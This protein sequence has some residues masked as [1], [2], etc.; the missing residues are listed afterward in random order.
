MLFCG[1]CG[2]MWQADAPT[3]SKQPRSIF[4]VDGDPSE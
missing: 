3:P 1:T 4:Q 2:H